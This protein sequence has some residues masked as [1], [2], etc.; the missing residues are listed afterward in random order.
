[1]HQR[2]GERAP[3]VG[4]ERKKAFEPEERICDFTSENKLISEKSGGRI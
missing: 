1:M 3:E 4:L 2:L